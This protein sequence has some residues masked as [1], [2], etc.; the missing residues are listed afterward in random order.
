MWHK[1]TLL[2]NNSTIFFF[3][4][5]KSLFYFV[6][7][8]I[9]KNLDLRNIKTLK[10]KTLFHSTVKYKKDKYTDKAIADIIKILFDY[11]VDLKTVIKD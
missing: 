1:L 6:K 4:C 8:L 7:T 3:L 5:N 9:N 11:S 10:N 2:A